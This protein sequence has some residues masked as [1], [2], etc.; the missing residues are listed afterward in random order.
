MRPSN[1]IILSDVVTFCAIALNIS[2]EIQ[3]DRTSRTCKVDTELPARTFFIFNH[4]SCVSNKSFNDD[5][6]FVSKISQI[7]HHLFLI[8]PILGK[9]I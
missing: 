8:W 3:S 9:K 1:F 5:T 4:Q 6:I 7:T 2:T